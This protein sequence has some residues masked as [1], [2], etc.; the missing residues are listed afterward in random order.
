MI[1]LVIVA[2]AMVVG[3]LVFLIVKSIATPKKVDSLQKMISQG[4]YN[5]VEK[6]A[7]AM[8]AKDPENFM[9]HYYLGKA[10]LMEKRNE[11]ALMEYKTVNENAVFGPEL[12]EMEFRKE[13]SQLYMQ[14]NQTQDALREYLLLTKM[15]PN[16][17]ENYYQVGKIY[18]QTNQSNQAFGFFKKTIQLNKKHAKA[19]ASIALILLQIKKYPEAKKEID[20][21][22][23]LSPETYSN[24]YYQGKILKE[25][26]DYGAAVK[27]FEKAQRDPEYKQKA[28]I[29]RG[30]CFMMGNMVDN[31]VSEFSRAIDMDKTGA[32]SDTLFAR[33]FLATCY[34]KNRKIEKAI[35]Q[36]QKIYAKN[37]AFRDVATKLD[38]Y[39][40]LAGNDSL[41]EYLTNN[42]E[43][44][45]EIC[46]QTCEKAMS[47]AVQKTETKKWGCQITAVDNKEDNWMSNRKQ[48]FLVRFYRNPEPIDDAAVRE[49]LDLSKS[50]KC[51]NAYMLS[52]ADF[53]KSALKF[54]EN[55][56]I[57][58]MGKEKLEA[59]LQKAGI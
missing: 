55:R 47:M 33:Y 39:K 41:K 45:S 53:T 36:W 3:F 9:A 24:F 12:P 28:L 48:L 27:A 2:L 18:E 52:S 15:D 20:L 1:W 51:Q 13:I 26:K 17:A 30:T 57:E 59:V 37:K 38:E 58:L 29:E 46:K 42:D 23:S 35:E 14:F 31:A 4:K 50:M 5:A 11:L 19:H 54:A 56:P 44:F 34:E 43:G 6:G 21:A 16:N 7:K 49:T 10:Y 40:D 25:Q 8:L 32:K 22:L